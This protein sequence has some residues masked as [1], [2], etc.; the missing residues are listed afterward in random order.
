M[1]IRNKLGQYTRSGFAK[2]ISTFKFIF[3][4]IKYL[5]TKDGAMQIIW[6]LGLGVAV[7]LCL[8]QIG[9]TAWTQAI[10]IGTKAFYKEPI[11]TQVTVPHAQES[12][13]N[14][15]RWT[16]GSEATLAKSVFKAE[17]GLRCEAEG[18]TDLQFTRNGIVYG[19]SYGI[20][21]I[22]Y[23]PGRP[24]PAQLKDC[25]FAI[26]YAKQLRDKQGFGIWSQYSNGEYKKFL[27]N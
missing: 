8:I 17:S 11:T 13:N 2:I 4:L 10:N 20:A 22:R 1:N 6:V 18:D 9:L 27:T 25:K 15:L 24:T 26:K 5:F 14:L 16:F 3:W 21:Q 23:L 19:A 12:I 7:S